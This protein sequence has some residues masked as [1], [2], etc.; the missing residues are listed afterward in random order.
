MTHSAYIYREAEY[1]E[2]NQIERSQRTPTTYD[3]YSKRAKM[4][5]LLWS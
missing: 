2:S 4:L 1:V 3:F 5:P